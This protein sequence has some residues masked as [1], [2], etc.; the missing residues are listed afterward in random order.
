MSCDLIL[1]PRPIP[2]LMGVLLQWPEGL[3]LAA[4]YFPTALCLLAGLLFFIASSIFKGGRDVQRAPV[5][6]MFHGSRR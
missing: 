5:R 3:N 4:C 2:A 6:L 1:R